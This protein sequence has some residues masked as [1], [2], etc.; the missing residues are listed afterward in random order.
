M[1]EN[2]YRIKLAVMIGLPGF[3]VR[4]EGKRHLKESLQAFRRQDGQY[5]RQVTQEEGQKAKCRKDHK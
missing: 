5:V 4:A 3:G 1:I 2:S